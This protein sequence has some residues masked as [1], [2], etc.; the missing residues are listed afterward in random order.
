MASISSPGPPSS[1]FA[2][3]AA[4]GSRTMMLSHSEAMPSPRGPTPPVVLRRAA[5]FGSARAA[6]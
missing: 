4:S 3:T 2:K 6:T 5:F 1:D